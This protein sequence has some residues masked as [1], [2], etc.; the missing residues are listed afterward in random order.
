M[1]KRHDPRTHFGPLLGLALLWAPLGCAPSG[2]SDRDDEDG[3][4]V[5][6]WVKNLGVEDGNL[7]TN[8]LIELEGGDLLAVGVKAWEFDDELQRDFWV[9]RLDSQGNTIWSRT[10]G[11]PVSRPGLGAFGTVRG[12]AASPSG[13][14]A[15]V[16]KAPGSGPAVAL[17]NGSEFDRIVT[18]G[19]ATESPA[20]IRA[21][22]S[23]NGG[24]AGWIVV[25]SSTRMRLGNVRKK[26]WVV[27]LDEVGEI[28]WDR[29]LLVS[30]GERA[31][32]ASASDVQE[33]PDGRFAVCGRRTEHFE[34]TPSQSGGFV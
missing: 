1:F 17:Y 32:S 7:V 2:G 24:T 30:A 9:S 31:T 19:R 5:S 3:T 26:A 34:F 14:S 21:V 29:F 25:G 23:R 16:F 8:D 27:R 28:M 20:R 10:Y 22:H 12:V 15:V 33:A 6:T 18:I 11:D 4:A 13:A